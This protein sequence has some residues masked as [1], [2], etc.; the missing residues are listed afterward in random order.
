M[1]LGSSWLCGVNQDHTETHSQLPSAM[2]LAVSWSV[3]LCNA[4]LTEGVCIMLRHFLKVLQ[5]SIALEF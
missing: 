4:E 3:C 1:R 5:L 2:K